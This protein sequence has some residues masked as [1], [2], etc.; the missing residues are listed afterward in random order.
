MKR[1]EE[2]QFNEKKYKEFIA[3]KPFKKDA[4]LILS[5]NLDYLEKKLKMAIN[6]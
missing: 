2:I 4:S 3:I 5:N 6:S 1:V